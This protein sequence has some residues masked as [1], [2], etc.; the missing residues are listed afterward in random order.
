MRE[1]TRNGK[2]RCARRPAGARPCRRKETA[3]RKLRVF[4]LGALGAALASLAYYHAAGL[5]RTD[6]PQAPMPSAPHPN[7]PAPQSPCLLPN[8]QLDIACTLPGGAHPDPD[9]V[10]VNKEID[11]TFQKSLAEMNSNAPGDEYGRIVLLGR[12]ELYDKNLSVNRNIACVT[13]HM[14]ETGFTS[15]VSLWNQTIVSNPGSVPI[16]NATG[17]MPNYRIEFRKPYPY[18]YSTFSP[19]LHYNRA[20]ENLFGGNFWDM[21]ATGIPATNPAASQAQDPPVDPQEQAFPDPACVI[22][23]ISRGPYAGYFRAIW[24]AQSFNVNWPPDTERVCATPNSSNAPHPRALN[25]AAVDRGT[26]MASYD[27]FAMAIAVNESSPEVSPFTSKFDMWLAGQAQLTPDEQRGFDLFNG[28]AR[29]NQCHL[30]GTGNA[31]L[32]TTRNGAGGTVAMTSDAP[33]FTDFQAHNIGVP[34][35]LGRPAYYFDRPDQYGYV[36]N[37]QGPA[38]ID[39]GVGQ[40]LRGPHNPSSAWAKLA[41]QFDGKFLTPT[42]RN[43]DKRPY[44]GFVKAYFHNGYAKSLKTVV[45]FYNTSQALPR[46]PQ[47]SPGEAVTCWPEPAVPA[48]VDTRFVGNLGLSGVEEDQIVAFLRTLTDAYYYSPK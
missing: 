46:C 9:V 25:L 5:P 38:Y 24:G 1:M 36:G 6:Q 4:A 45:H 12:L 10:R 16:T 15:A 21:R 28:R 17:L 29:C 14:P 41:D 13:C 37:P 31:Q 32:R 19:I 48:N 22:Y 7:T 43:V 27:H 39:K 34:R 23:R 18:C 30:S 11:D 20:Q 2:S 47:G 42:L 35:N 44:P 40:F 26:V 3:V 33:L 8:G